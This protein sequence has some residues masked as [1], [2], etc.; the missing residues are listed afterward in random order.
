MKPSEFKERRDYD[1]GFTV[2]F[3]AEDYVMKFVV[4]QRCPTGEFPGEDEAGC[5]RIFDNPDDA[6][7]LIDGQIKWDGCCDIDIGGTGGSY[8][9]HFCGKKDAAVVGRA[10]NFAY[11]LAKHNIGHWSE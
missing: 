5:S 10:L 3:T 8:R 4:V 7:Q 6:A 11:Y 9:Q 1:S 2:F